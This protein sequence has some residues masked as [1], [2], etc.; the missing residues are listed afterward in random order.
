MA[1]VEGQPGSWA[2]VLLGTALRAGLIGSVLYFYPKSNR[3]LGTIA[4]QSLA[5]SAVVTTVL[6]A[7]HAVRRRV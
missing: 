1:V 5:A 7:A 2:S 4:G 3:R 6:M